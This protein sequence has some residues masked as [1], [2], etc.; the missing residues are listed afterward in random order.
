MQ[1]VPAFVE[2]MEL[3]SCISRL[4]QRN[5]ACASA[6]TWSFRFWT[7]SQDVASAWGHLDW[8]E[9]RSWT[10]K[11]RVTKMSPSR[12][13]RYLT[14]AITIHFFYMICHD[15]LRPQLFLAVGVSNMLPTTVHMSPCNLFI[16]PWREC[17]NIEQGCVRLYP[18]PHSHI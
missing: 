10:F 15:K 14:T 5:R 16:N 3:F 17:V 13:C 7:S 9:G 1:C 4:R 8:L 12:P 2:A 11:A 6:H 18:W